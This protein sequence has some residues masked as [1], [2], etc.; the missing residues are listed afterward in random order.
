MRHGASGPLE[1]KSIQM[2]DKSEKHFI[3]TY[4]KLD[5]IPNPDFLYPQ[6]PDIYKTKDWSF[7]LTIVESHLESVFWLWQYQNPESQKNV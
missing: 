6:I 3:S 5:P 7:C 1:E 2:D 4:F